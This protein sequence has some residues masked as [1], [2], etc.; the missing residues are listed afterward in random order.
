MSQSSGSVLLGRGGRDVYTQRGGEDLC[1]I[2]QLNM[3]SVFQLLAFFGPV[4]FSRPVTTASVDFFARDSRAIGFFCRAKRIPSKN[5]E[6]IRRFFPLN[7]PLYAA[8]I[9]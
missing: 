9:A 6:R 2:T 1:C 5:L 3:L 7:G 4:A 8:L